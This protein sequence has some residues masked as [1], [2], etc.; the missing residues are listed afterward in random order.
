MC[1]ILT[2]YKVK[3]IPHLIAL[4]VVVATAHTL[5]LR[6]NMY[7][8]MLNERIEDLNTYIHDDHGCPLLFILRLQI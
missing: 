1:A 5:I 7:E 3:E 4:Y 2:E 8:P 6:I